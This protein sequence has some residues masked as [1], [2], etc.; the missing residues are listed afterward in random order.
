MKKII[1]LILL[2][3]VFLI[4]TGYGQ[5]SFGVSPGL[6]LN[7]AYFGYQVNNRIVPFVGFQNLNVNVSN[8]YDRYD[9]NYETGQLEHNTNSEEFKMNILLPYIGVKY[10]FLSQNKIKAYASTIVTMPIATGKYEGNNTTNEDNIF[11]NMSA[12]GAEFGFGAEYFFDESFSLG[13]EFGVR[14]FHF[15]QSYT[16]Q[17]NGK[18]STDEYTYNISPTY[19]KISL[20][21]YFN[22]KK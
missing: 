21:Y 3:L 8:S 9:M 20:N 18:D 4:S 19:N 5:F 13:G 11:E 1:I 15:N 17:Y 7:G 14:Y 12:F 10:F 22:R 2:S 16:R 6:N